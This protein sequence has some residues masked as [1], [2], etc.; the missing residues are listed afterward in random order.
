MENLSCFGNYIVI[1]YNNMWT[2]AST[3]YTTVLPVD[4][5]LE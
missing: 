3:K 1:H 4:S 2:Y 5:K